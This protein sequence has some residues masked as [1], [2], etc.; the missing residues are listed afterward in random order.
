MLHKFFLST[1]LLLALLATQPASAHEYHASITDVK[2]NPRTQHLE[3]AVKVFMDDLEQLLSQRAKAKVV[4]SG[5]SA[6]VQQ[7]LAAY[8]STALTFELE[9]GKPLKSRL[10]G[11]EEEADVVWLYIEVPVQ[12]ATLRQLY[13]KNAI[14]T[15]LFSD[16]MNIVNVNHMGKTESVLM[17]RG[18][19]GKKLTF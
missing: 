1:V 10:V 18:D 7:Q 5:S 12:Q 19:T 14:L 6:A 11:S 15:D 17:Q 4:Y 2:F 13:I 9:K 16:Q 8:L 3:V